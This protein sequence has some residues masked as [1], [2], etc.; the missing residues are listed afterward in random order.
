MSDV[1][2]VKLGGSL[3]ADPRLDEALRRLAR[4]GVVIVPGGG[5]F[6]DAVRAAQ[7]PLRFDEA[8]AHAMAILAMAQTAHLLH[9]RCPALRL[10]A[11]P[12]RIAATLAAGQPACWQPT[13]VPDA[14]VG[15]HITS[16]SLAAWL[17]RQLGAARL[18]LVKADG[19]PAAAVS[20]ATDWQ[21][22]AAR[23]WVD[24]AFAAMASRCGAAVALYRLND[25]SRLN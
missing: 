25:F 12:A 6:A 22:W 14:E 16:D 2:V 9:S 19:V 7:G 4:P 21:D 3:L 24:T 5:V 23:G 13:G 11:T 17:A 15:W 10:A 18:V 1:T 20:E 8:A